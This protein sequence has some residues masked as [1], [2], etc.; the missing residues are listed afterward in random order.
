MS[1]ANLCSSHMPSW[2]GTTLSLLSLLPVACSYLKLV[3]VQYLQS[4]R[5]LFHRTD[6]GHLSSSTGHKY[7]EKR[8]KTLCK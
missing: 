2:Q 7:V 8:G 4:L 3:P 6:D 1:G 5:H